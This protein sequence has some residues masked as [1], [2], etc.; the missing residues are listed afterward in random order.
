MLKSIEV[1][2]EI[3]K[4]FKGRLI[5]SS[6]LIPYG[7]DDSLIN[8]IDVLVYTKSLRIEG[9]RSYLHDR[10]FL[11]TDRPVDE[12]GYQ[13]YQ[14]SL[15]FESKKYDKPIHLALTKQPPIIYSVGK[16]VSCKMDRANKTDI[17]QLKN[18]FK[19]YGS[20]NNV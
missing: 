17:I 2:K 15:V 13:F 10:G 7:L 16:I 3:Q 19:N 8:D 14:G 18:L 11:E 12:K 9:I 5:G 4:Y 6:L 1:V 20:K